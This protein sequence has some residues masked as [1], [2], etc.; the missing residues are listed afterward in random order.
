MM[1]AVIVAAHPDDEM[2]GLGAFLPTLAYKFS[3]IHITDGAPRSGDDAR[4]AGCATWQEYAA[5]R[6]REFRDALE[7][8]D[9]PDAP[10]LCLDCPDQ[11]A[12][13]RIAGHAHRL[14]GIFDELSPSVVFTHA[15]EG[16]HPDHDAT[17]A[18]VHAAMRLRKGPCQIT[19]FAGYHAGA[20]GIECECFLENG[21]DVQIRSLTDRESRR[22]RELLNC[23]AS[24]ARV[25]VQFPL[26]NEPLRPAPNY[27]FCRPPHQGALYYERFEWGVQAAQWLDVSRRAFRDLGIPCVC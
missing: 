1:H 25:L 14:A 6:R 21:V 15:Y 10:T 23:F 19:E 3:F 7:A 13:F 27:D 5:M 22:K 2:L 4:H 18:A 12:V 16:G 11:E 9:A 20:N 24:R 26:R 17:A 8:L